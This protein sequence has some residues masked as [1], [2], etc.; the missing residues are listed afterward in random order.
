MKIWF[1]SDTHNKHRQLKVPT[2]V[3]AVIH[4]GD[5]SEA[6]DPWTNEHEARDFFE[7]YSSLPIE[8]KFFVPG[9][10]STAME[11]GLVQASEYPSVHFLVHEQ[12][13]WAGLKIFGSPYTP[14][15]FDWAYMKPRSELDAVWQS[16][17]EGIDILITHGPPKGLFDL[18]R[19]MD[20][21]GPVHVGSM[22]LMKHV[23]HRIQ[24]RIHCFGHIHDER[25]FSNYGAI[26]RGQTHFINCACCDNANRLKHHGHVHDTR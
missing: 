24:P 2:D 23:E 5:E 4:S 14:Q 12:R 20:T 19:D 25:N 17:P 8:A 1:I 16:I 22:S 26:T 15:F 3:D 11:Q 10:H 13:E 18:T 21:G 6:R 9:N 7:W